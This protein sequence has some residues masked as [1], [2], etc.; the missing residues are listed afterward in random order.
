MI[1]VPIDSLVPGTTTAKAVVTPSGMMLVG[2]GT[3]LNGTLI[4][5]L[6]GMGVAAVFVEGD[7]EGA[8]GGT[9]PSVED[10]LAELTRRFAPHAADP[11]M[12]ELR[13]TLSQQLQTT[14]AAKPR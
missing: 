4:S 7:A 12:V 9:V 3:V 14:H 1:Q 5:R 13:D 6:K 2:V 10:R 11:L 8:G